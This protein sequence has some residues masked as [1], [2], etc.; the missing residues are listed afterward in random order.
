MK[1][2]QG[3]TSLLEMIK[4]S[5]SNNISNIDKQHVT[6]SLDFILSS[7]FNPE[8]LDVMIKSNPRKFAPLLAK[9]LLHLVEPLLLSMNE[10]VKQPNLLK[11]IFKAVCAGFLISQQLNV[12]EVDEQV[13]VSDA[14]MSYLILLN[15]SSSD[16]KTADF[17]KKLAQLMHTTFKLMHQFNFKRE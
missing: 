3:L 1:S 7:L 14:N 8:I 2:Q 13:D 12:T 11:V 4:F 5:L 10:L 17:E 16:V 9:S 6:E 15:R